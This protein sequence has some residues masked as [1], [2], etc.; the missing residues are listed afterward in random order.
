MMLDRMKYFAKDL[1]R[2]VKLR[3]YR[4]RGS[5]LVDAGV[6]ICGGG[7]LYWAGGET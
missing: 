5:F 4:S 6:S 3:L 1:P 2:W 7:R